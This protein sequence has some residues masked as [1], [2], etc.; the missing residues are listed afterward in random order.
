MRRKT[1]LVS[2]AAAR[3]VMALASAAFLLPCTSSPKDSSTAQ[4]EL[5][6]TRA[7]PAPAPVPAPAPIPSVHAD[8]HVIHN[9]HYLNE[10][11]ISGGVPVGDEAF[12][13][14]KA[15]GVR[16]IISV[17]GATPDVA[18]AEA[19]GIRY[20][21]IPITYAEVTEEETL[22]IARA[23]RDLPG[24]VFVHCHHGKHRSPAAVAA[25]GAALGIVTPE[26][27]IAF[28]KT[29]G[30]AP[31]YVGLYACVAAMTVANPAVI[32]AA[33]ADFPSVRQ[34]EGMVA[35][36]VEVDAAYEFLGEI[37]AAGWK[38]P[39]NHP[40]LIPAV[41]AGKLAD[42]L[43][44]SGEDPKSV[45]FGPD[46]VQKLTDAIAVATAMEEAFV[47]GAPAADLEARY[48]LVQASCKDCHA[49]YRDVPPA[50]K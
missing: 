17:D 35:A 33:P 30:T 25:A 40:D 15:M 46:Y 45:E 50:R 23:M 14:L 16:T 12:D 21:H 36:M 20:V 11:I 41:E 32:D 42:N 8:S 5:N 27:G 9:I 18:R 13:E 47:A 29:A 37:R 28:M 19:R 24:P 49:N 38:A 34:A 26:E 39:A 43:R 7:A 3:R 2:T 6:N 48:K 10:R 31:S 1:R 44:F 4:C 22:E